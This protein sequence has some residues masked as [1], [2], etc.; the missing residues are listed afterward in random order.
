MGW[1]GN[2]KIRHKLVLLVIIPMVGFFHFGAARVSETRATS[3][4]SASLVH[5]VNLSIYV[6][7]LVHETQLERAM[8]VG[9]M[10]SSSNRYNLALSEQRGVV[11]EN[12]Y[13]LEKYFLSI[14]DEIVSEKL[15]KEFQKSFSNIQALVSIRAVVDKRRHQDEQV[16][17]NYFGNLNTRLVDTIRYFAQYSP[18]TSLNTKLVSYNSLVVGKESAAQER[19]L[20]TGVLSRNAVGLEEIRKIAELENQQVAA[21]ERL[22]HGLSPDLFALYRKIES[23]FTWA[24]VQKIRN[25]IYHGETLRQIYGRLL[26]NQGYDGLVDHFKS[27][28]SQHD[29]KSAEAFQQSY[30]GIRAMLVTLLA[31]DGLS[32]NQKSSLRLIQDAMDNYKTNVAKAKNLI[33]SEQDVKGLYA[34]LAVDDALMTDAISSLAKEPFS[35]ASQDEWF[36]VST[37]RI[38]LLKELETDVTKDILSSAE[39]LIIEAKGVEQRTLSSII[40]GAALTIMLLLWVSSLIIQPIK[41]TAEVA[42][43]IA[44]GDLSRDISI[45][46]T[47]DEIGQLSRSIES[48]VESLRTARN[49]D[50]KE[51]WIKT[52]QAKILETMRNVQEL[53][54]LARNIIGQ[55]TTYIGGQIGVLYFVDSPKTLSFLGGYACKRQDMVRERFR[56]GS[57]LIGQAAL[58]NEAIVLDDIPEDYF[59]IFSGAGQRAPRNIVIFP[60]FTD[61]AVR[62][63]LEIGSLKPI[64]D[65]ALD[66]FRLVSEPIAMALM[67]SRSRSVLERSNAR[68][69]EKTLRL[70][71]SEDELKRQGEELMASNA[72]LVKNQEVLSK[73][74][75]LLEATRLELEEKANALARASRY[76]SEFLANMSHELRTPLNS[77]LLLSSQLVQNK[78]KNLTP[79][80]LEDANIIYRAGKSLLALINDILDLSKVEA[81]VLALNITTVR[82]VDC[83]AYLQEL[84]RG[85]AEEKGLSYSVEVASDAPATIQTDGKRLEQILINFVSNAFKFTEKGTV[86]VSFGLPEGGKFLFNGEEVPVS[87]IAIAVSDTGIGISADKQDVIFE[88]FQQEDGSISRR[89]GGTGLGLSISRELAAL[90]GGEVRVSSIKGRGSTFALY[91]PVAASAIISSDSRYLSSNAIS[92]GD[93]LLAAER[94]VSSG[95][96]VSRQHDKW[97]ELRDRRVLIVDNDMRNAF[98]LSRELA[99]AGLDVSMASSGEM[100]LEK[101]VKENV[102][103]LILLDTSLATADGQDL[104]KRIRQIRDYGSIPIVGISHEAAFNSDSEEIC[105]SFAVTCMAPPIMVDELLEYFSE[106]L[107]ATTVGS[108]ADESET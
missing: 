73:Q 54:L 22:S 59:Q 53:P 51:R 89:Y 19:A 44:E 1:F 39:R 98:V 103:E 102:F 84:F 101:L 92:S 97:K 91:L 72:E 104:M 57:G 46:V 71:Q 23:D 81:G 25:G 70:Q 58:T 85:V 94:N 47:N 37:T 87:A 10:T 49:N 41:A 27:Y 28:I 88:A 7:N 4:E 9:Y 15:K 82:I 45:Q 29:E 5:L 96:A 108:I 26:G 107:N 36:D 6:G 78:D 93:D 76:K 40:I 105:S 75:D 55:M 79:G 20:I 62:G 52:G 56:I 3:Q 43:R 50:E 63:V 66:L 12:R 18:R 99:R 48:M 21:F 69:E 100:A 11:D 67:A 38:D 13:L 17:I 42:K 95:L 16:V 61:G 32:Q 74:R 33:E 106:A 64:S 86:T 83:A 35:R 24:K 8:S 80:Q 34:M 90:L 77:L 68:L 2:V 14:S 31:S 30:E 60:L 65:E